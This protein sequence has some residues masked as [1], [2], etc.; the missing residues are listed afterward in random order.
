MLKAPVA[1]LDS[2]R[3]SPKTVIF[4]GSSPAR[5][6]CKFL[7]LDCICRMMVNKKELSC[8]CIR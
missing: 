6:I 8:F 1:K 7:G 2:R 3:G 4:A 5:G